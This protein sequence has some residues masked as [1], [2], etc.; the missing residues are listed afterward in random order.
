MEEYYDVDKRMSDPKILESTLASFLDTS[1]FDISKREK[2]PGY[3]NTK[4]ALTTI[5][6]YL[7]MVHNDPSIHYNPVPADADIRIY[8]LIVS[9]VARHYSMFKITGRFPEEMVRAKKMLDI[10]YYLEDGIN[11]DVFPENKRVVPG[12][13]ERGDD[14]NMDE[15]GIKR[16]KGI[17]RTD[18]DNIQRRKIGILDHAKV[19][20]REH[21]K[22]ALR[23]MNIAADVKLLFVFGK[24]CYYAILGLQPPMRFSIIQA[25]RDTA[26]LNDHYAEMIKQITNELKLENN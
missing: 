17:L 16:I 5:F 18:P 6:G 13:V 24:I 11:N 21:Y 1:S 7:V 12:S 15:D 26:G 23:E 9:E 3:L 19:F 8:G 22:N 25:E 2:V 10:F 14:I 20:F 4:D